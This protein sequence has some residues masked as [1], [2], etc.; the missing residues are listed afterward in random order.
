[1]LLS[2]FLAILLPS[3]PVLSLDS[4]CINP[5]RS[6]DQAEGATPLC[7]G[8]D[9]S[10]YKSPSLQLFII[11]TRSWNPPTCDSAQLRDY[12]LQ[13]SNQLRKLDFIASNQS[14]AAYEQVPSLRV[15]QIRREARYSGSD[16]YS[17][18]VQVRAVQYH[19]FEHDFQ[20]TR[21]CS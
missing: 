19:H 15:R 18:C 4:I 14:S 12:W 20:H 21:Q 6:S 11:P 13:G 5:Y 10:P 2:I 3:I 1:M 8:I 9:N 16:E 7:S 17:T